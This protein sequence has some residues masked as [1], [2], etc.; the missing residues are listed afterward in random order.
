MHK[1]KLIFNPLANHGR[2]GQQASDLRTLV[3]KLGGA[4]W[5]GTEYPAHATELAEQ[6]GNEGYEAV[7]ALGGDGTV[8]EIVNGLMRL[9]EDRR[10]A[11]GVVPIGSGNEF[12]F[13]AKIKANPPEALEAAFRGSPAPVD[14]GQIS[15]GDGRTEYWDNSCGMMFDAAVNIQSR[16]ITR[17]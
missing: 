10:P 5:A 15:D 11:L 2:S 13:N 8:H 4:D 16:R 1:A 14:V 17:E 6:A 7:I 3:E 9:P 12:A